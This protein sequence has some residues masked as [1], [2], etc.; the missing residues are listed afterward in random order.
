VAKQPKIH[1]I[2]I[3]A[4]M[5]WAMCSAPVREAG[6]LAVHTRKEFNTL[7]KEERCLRCDAIVNGKKST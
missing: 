7:P 6:R 3:A 2:P 5:K 1:L 4:G